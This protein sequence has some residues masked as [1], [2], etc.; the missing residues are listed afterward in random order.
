MF[1][2]NT[3]IAGKSLCDDARPRAFAAAG[4]HAG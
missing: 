2:Y 1:P 4:I 3:K